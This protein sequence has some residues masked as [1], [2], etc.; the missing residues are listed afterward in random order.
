M[1]LSDMDRKT[2]ILLRAL[3]RRD[4]NSLDFLSIPNQETHDNEV[5]ININTGEFF[6]QFII[7]SLKYVYLLKYLY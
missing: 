1:L 2:K 3:N 4:V 5:A 6:V 7:G